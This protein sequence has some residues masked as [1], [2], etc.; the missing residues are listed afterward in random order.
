MPK[1]KW[2]TLVSLHN[3]QNTALPVALSQL[4]FS[5][6]MTSSELFF[7]L[8]FSSRY[9]GWRRRAVTRPSLAFS[10]CPFSPGQ[11]WCVAAAAAAAAVVI[12]A[13]RTNVIFGIP[14]SPISFFTIIR[15]HGYLSLSPYLKVFYLGPAFPLSSWQRPTGIVTTTCRVSTRRSGEYSR[16]QASRCPSNSRW[17][18]T[19]DRRYTV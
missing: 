13:S 16:G 14:V 3:G 10:T 6:L 5:S 11:I 19:L 15:I 7:G 17:L 12:P 18:R 1:L 4:L 9:R 2:I 8:K